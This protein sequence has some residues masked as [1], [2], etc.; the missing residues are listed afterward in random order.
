MGLYDVHMFMSC[1]M[2]TL[3]SPVELVYLHG[4]IAA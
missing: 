1:P 3:S 2:L 4:F